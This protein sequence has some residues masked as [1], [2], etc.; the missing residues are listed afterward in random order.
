MLSKR[1]LVRKRREYSN[2]RLWAIAPNGERSLSTPVGPQ[3]AEIHWLSRLRVLAGAARR[4]RL[5]AF[6][7][8]I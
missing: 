5:S 2:Q 4:S 7:R 8:L 1:D 3:G 6:S